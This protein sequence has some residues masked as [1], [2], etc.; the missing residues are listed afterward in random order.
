MIENV[1]QRQ[2]LLAR[3]TNHGDGRSVFPKNGCVMVIPIAST[4]L[5]KILLCIIV[6]HLSLALKIN[7]LVKMVVVLIR[8]GLVIMTMI[9]GM[10][11][12]KENSVTHNIKHVRLKSLLAKTSNASGTNTDAVKKKKNIFHEYRKKFDI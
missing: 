4:V 12:T 8:D 6:Q 5:M 10:D 3:R 7:F 2:N 9:V 1:M 11:R